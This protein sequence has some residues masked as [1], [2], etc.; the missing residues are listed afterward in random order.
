[1]EYPEYLK[2]LAPFLKKI[3]LG[4]VCYMNGYY[5]VD[6]YMALFLQP[7]SKLELQHNEDRKEGERVLITVLFDRFTIL[8]PHY[9]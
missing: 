7:D 9:Q 4:V 6:H 8:P 5:I 1:M 2:P 3:S